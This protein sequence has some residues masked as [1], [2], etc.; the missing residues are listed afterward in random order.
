MRIN[1][2]YTWDPAS[3]TFEYSGNSY[4]LDLIMDE[5]GW[6]KRQ[7]TDALSERKEILEYMAERGINNYKEISQIVQQY[8]LD[9]DAVLTAIGK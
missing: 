6:T 7:L 8:A 9:P 3:D 5:R 2:L 4:V 1:D